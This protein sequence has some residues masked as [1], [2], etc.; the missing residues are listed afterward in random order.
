MI[1]AGGV[2]YDFPMRLT[3]KNADEGSWGPG[4]LVAC[5]E[6]SL[7]RFLFFVRFFGFGPARK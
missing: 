2:M 1:I 3:V 6:Q 4:D 7:A 5:D